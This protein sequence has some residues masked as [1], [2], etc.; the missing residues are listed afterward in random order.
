MISIL[1]LPAIMG[2]FGGT[3]TTKKRDDGSFSIE[4]LHH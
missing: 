3:Y 2:S 4:L 1:A